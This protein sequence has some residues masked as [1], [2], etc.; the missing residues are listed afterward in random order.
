M[1]APTIG[2]LRL[3]S[4]AALAPG[5]AHTTLHLDDTGARPAVATERAARVDAAPR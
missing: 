4:R 2:H 1:R 5:T 3:E